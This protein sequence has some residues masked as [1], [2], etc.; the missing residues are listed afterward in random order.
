MAAHQFVPASDERFDHALLRQAY[1]CF[2]SG[3]TAF[4]GMIDSKP[5]G[6]A[7]SSFTSVSMDP[8]LVSVCVADTSST[9]PRLAGLGTLGLSVLAS[10]HGTV[11][12]ALATKG[13]DRFENVDWAETASGAVFVHGAT[14]WMEC[15]P[16]NVIDA[17][18]HQIVVL[19]I[20][21]L[22]INPDAEPM[23]FHRSA[24]HEI[25]RIA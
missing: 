9:W 25:A 7:A 8:P 19:R 3:V 22:L 4:C 15:V 6:M 11:A 24:F 21:A 10:D 2:P 18:D 13:V 14:L 20:E 12:R 5:E 16:F 23:V 17:G 1:G